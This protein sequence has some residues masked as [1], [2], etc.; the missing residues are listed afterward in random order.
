MTLKPYYDSGGITIYHG[1]CREILPR[2]K[3]V[4]VVLTDPPY[5]VGINYGAHNDKMSEPDWQE[6][7]S[8]WFLPCIGIAQTTLVTGQARL[9]FY[10]MLQPWKWLLCWHKPAAM[11]RSPVGFCNWEPVALWGRGSNAGCDFVTAPIRPDPAIDGHPCPKPLAWATGVLKLFPWAS[12]VLD[13]FMGTGTTLVAARDMGLRAIGIEI[14]E[15][16]CEIA[17]NRM[18]QGVL[19]GEPNAEDMHRGAL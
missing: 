16:Y 6:W 19:F 3:A 15:R 14:E 5:N 1:D 18:R 4:D 8:S 9:P 10:A 17:A 2:I 7:A 12:S 11:G 13:P